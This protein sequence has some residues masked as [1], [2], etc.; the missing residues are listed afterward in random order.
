MA[1]V[2]I[3]VKEVLTHCYLVET[4]ETDPVRIGDMFYGLTEQEQGKL[5]ESSDCESWNIID[6]MTE[7][8]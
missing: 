4:G 5:L 6:V 2:K 8:E 1:L 3:Y 7:G